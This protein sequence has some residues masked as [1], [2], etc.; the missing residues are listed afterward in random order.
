MLQVG[1]R[2]LRARV[3]LLTATQLANLRRDWGCAYMPALISVTAGMSA[4][5]WLLRLIQLVS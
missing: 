5:C 3:A 2:T 4:G 1:M